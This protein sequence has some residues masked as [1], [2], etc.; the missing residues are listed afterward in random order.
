MSS[1]YY[2]RSQGKVL[3]PF[4]FEDLKAKAAKG[5]LKKTDQIST[6]KKAWQPARGVEGL[7]AP[8]PKAPKPVPAEPAAAVKELELVEVQL[9]E[10]EPLEAAI[11]EE[12]AEWHYCLPGDGQ[13]QGPVLESK[14]RKLLQSGRLPQDTL[15]WNETLSDWVEATRIP[16]LFG[17]RARGGAD[18]VLFTEV[19]LMEPGAA[20]PAGSGS[21]L[22]IPPLASTSLILG[23]LG[24]VLG[25]V[26][27]I[28]T[29]IK[30]EVGFVI[31]L[32]IPAAVASILAI[33]FGHVA[34]GQIQA[35]R[36]VFQGQGLA[37]AGLI[38]GYLI[39]GSLILGGLVWI[40]IKMNNG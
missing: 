8:S 18:P 23:I 28:L 31:G 3:G 32:F 25:I 38:L 39:L 19:P 26:G 17:G 12:E 40:A 13:T 36:R 29:L 4:S 14:L 10:D 24:V 37:K 33:I 21:H 22:P 27:L 11:A 7:F 15:V 2:V 5:H 9:I 20:Y 34:G 6:D 30:A 35:N 16:A 1:S